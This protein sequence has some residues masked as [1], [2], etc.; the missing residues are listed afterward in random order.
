MR[1][2]SWLGNDV[3]GASDSDRFE[4]GAGVA[5]APLPPPQ[6]PP[7]QTGSAGPAPAPNHR[8]AKEEK[9]ETLRRRTTRSLNKSHLEQEYR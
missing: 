5:V 4:K 3:S 8:P 7:T 9:D 1:S 2:D 6:V